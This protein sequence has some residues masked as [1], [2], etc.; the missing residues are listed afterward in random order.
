MQITSYGELKQ[1][2]LWIA[3]AGQ[4]ITVS[5]Y[6]IDGL[7]ID[8]GPI[9]MRKQLMQLFNEWP[10]NEVV[11]TH[12]H[13]DHTGM[14]NWLQTNKEVPIYIHESG[15]EKCIA[16][17][18]LP[19][20]RKVFWGERACFQPL[21][22]NETFKTPHYTWDVIHTPG[23]ADDHVALYNQ[24]KRWMFG[25]DLYVQSNPKSLF[26]FESVPLT[27]QSL[28]LLLTYDFEVYICAHAGY[29]KEGR[30]AIEEKLNYLE[31][32]ERQVLRLNTEGHTKRQIQKMLFPKRHPMNY[33][34]LFENS[35]RHIVNSILK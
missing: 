8:T 23:H 35:P 29:I 7:L 27:I 24:E 9:K 19:L 2:Q 4:R 30:K 5:V 25:G 1:A 34:T 22:L 28:R 18:K 11:L 20:Y 21:A 6:L 17:I 32:I 13:E 12:H 15:I 26:S 3:L 16:P 14:A 31:E 10:I 33:L